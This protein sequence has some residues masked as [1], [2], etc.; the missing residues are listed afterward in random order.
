M[1]LLN[2]KESYLRDSLDYEAPF[3]FYI[4]FRNIILYIIFIYSILPLVGNLSI[5]TLYKLTHKSVRDGQF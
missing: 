5:L 2:R 4:H 3:I 1:E